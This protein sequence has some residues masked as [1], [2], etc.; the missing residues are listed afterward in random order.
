MTQYLPLS[1]ADI[2][3]LALRP[4]EFQHV[5]GDVWGLEQPNT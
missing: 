2:A 4:Q 3:L 5:E 1:P